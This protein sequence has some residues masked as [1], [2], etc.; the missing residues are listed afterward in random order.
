[1]YVVPFTIF[2]FVFVGV[3]I[4]I[5]IAIVTTHITPL[6]IDI[7]KSIFVFI[8]FFAT[9]IMLGFLYFP[10][11]NLLGRNIRVKVILGS[12]VHKISPFVNFLYHRKTKGLKSKIRKYII[13]VTKG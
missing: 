2:I 11:E 4:I 7:T 10:V 9:L 3:T 8:T 12:L 13:K 5:R 1:M 6:F